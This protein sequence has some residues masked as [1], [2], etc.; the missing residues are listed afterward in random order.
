M[1][2]SRVRALIS[3]VIACAISV[4]ACG[5]LSG[6]SAAAGNVA[7]AFYSA[8]QNGHGTQACHLLAFNVAHQLKQSSGKPCAQ[9]VTHAGLNNPGHVTRVGSYGHSAWAV[10]EKDT[11]FLSV[12]PGGWRVTAAGCTP[13]GDRPYDCLVKG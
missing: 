2:S 1:C 5:S 10:F 4:V 9:A 3:L 8:V 13:R 7:R 12:F 6:D 11:V